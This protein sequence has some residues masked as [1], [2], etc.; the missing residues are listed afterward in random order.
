MEFLVKRSS[1]AEGVRQGDPLFPMLFL[2]AMEPLHKL[3][4][5]AQ[6]SGLLNSL[7][8][9]CDTFKMSLYAD[10]VAVF[11]K[12]NLSE[13]KAIIH[14][15]SIFAEALGL[16]T[17]LEKTECYPIQCDGLDISFPTSSNISIAQFP[18]KYLGLPLH[19]QKKPLQNYV[20]GSHR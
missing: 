17:N 5:K 1:T 19:Y 4:T 20:A 11:I 12:P 15:M 10:D 7:S 9:N 14:I 18:C 16:H 2:L 3:V 6:Q 13:L 8:K